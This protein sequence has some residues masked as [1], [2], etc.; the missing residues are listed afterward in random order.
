MSWIQSFSMTNSSVRQQ[1]YAKQQPPECVAYR[2]LGTGAG[3]FTE[4]RGIVKAGQL[5][6]EQ[7]FWRTG[8]KN[9]AKRNGRHLP[10]V[11]NSRTLCRAKGF[12]VSGKAAQSEAGYHVFYTPLTSIL[13][14]VADY[15][16]SICF[17][18]WLMGV[19]SLKII[20]RA[21]GQWHFSALLNF[22]SYATI[23]LFIC[24]F[25][26]PITCRYSNIPK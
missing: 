2:S 14:P 21:T 22:Q 18:L 4:V 1:V 17:A 19:N 6:R 5:T 8:N 23:Y 16:Q 20:S 7:N 12:Y 25:P 3:T 24:S 26:L 9:K 10:H 13:I 11:C 15:V